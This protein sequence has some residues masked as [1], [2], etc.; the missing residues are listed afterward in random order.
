MGKAHKSRL[1]E[2]G[3]SETIPKVEQQAD[4]QC[5][6]QEAAQEEPENQQAKSQVE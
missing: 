6:A 1:Q 5:M 4:G 3:G 2:K